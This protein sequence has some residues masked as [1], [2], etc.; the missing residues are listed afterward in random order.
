[1]ARVIPQTLLQQFA[2]H[3]SQALYAEQRECERKMGKGGCRDFKE[4]KKL[5]GK[6]EG[7]ELAV[8]TINTLV[9]RAELAAD[10]DEDTPEGAQTRKRGAK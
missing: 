7:L 2:N 1:M 5:S 9:N 3:V 6:V 4:Y 10:D 8:A